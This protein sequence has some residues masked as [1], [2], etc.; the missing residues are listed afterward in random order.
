MALSS[1]RVGAS[2]TALTKPVDARWLMAYAAGIGDAAPCYFDTRLPAGIVGHPLFP[3]CLEWD[4]VLAAQAISEHALGGDEL[5]RGVHA[6]HDMQIHRLVRAGDVLT[7]T[8]TVEGVERRRPGAYET[9]RLETVDATGASVSTTH[10]G[11]LFLGVDV[12]GPDRPLPDASPADAPF[13]DAS[14]LRSTI[15]KVEAGAAH[16]YTECARIW[17][18]I[19]TDAAVAEAASLPGILLHGTQSLAF[20]VSEIVSA[21]AGGDPSQVRRVR[22]RFGAMVLVPSSLTIHVRAVHDA[23][24]VDGVREVFFEVR[25][26]AGEAAIK[27]GSVVVDGRQRRSSHESPT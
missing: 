4:A 14:P 3:V 21:F 5:V 8:A 10:M 17:N 15:R 26:A 9:L 23:A 27:S 1:L 7:T 11:M 16:V 12:E 24:L 2:T 18:P 19:H 13:G 25:N 20:A 6:T 22:C